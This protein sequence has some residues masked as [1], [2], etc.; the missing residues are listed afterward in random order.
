MPA[1][2][3]RSILE[4]AMEENEQTPSPGELDQPDTAHR[5]RIWRLDQFIA[6]GFDVARDP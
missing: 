6:L 5:T 4:R 2:A 1:R 3:R